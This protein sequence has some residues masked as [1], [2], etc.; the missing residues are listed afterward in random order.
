MPAITTL[1]NLSH[2]GLIEFAGE[3][4]L[5]FLQG[6]LSCDVENLQIWHAQYGSYNTPKG[7]MLASFL[8]WR[9]ADA[10]YMQ[11]PRG[12][13]EPVRKR[14]AIFIL[15]SKV[16]VTDASDGW[17]LFGI[18]GTNAEQLLKKKLGPVPSTPMEMTTAE[19][20]SILKLDSTRFQIIAE[21]DYASQVRDVLADE[22][23]PASREAW[24]LLDIRAGIPFVLPETQ[25][26]FVPQMANLDLVGGVSFSK[27]CYPGQEIVAR[28]HY[29]G[30][31]KQR[32]YLA[33]IETAD[34]PN[35][36]DKVFSSMLGEQAAG[37]LVNAAPVP[38]GGYD[39]LVVMQ[40]ESAGSGD[41]HW[42]SL[43]GPRLQL[44][45]LPYEIPS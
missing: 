12:L 8:L 2:F 33:R 43:D 16:R 34:P 9:T 35:A 45:S 37:M 10:Y 25:E 22:T 40:I 3:E 11:L 41:I 39:A 20:V 15:R 29:L 26:Q 28:M 44:K 21:A 6:Q 17:A 13:C 36:G 38:G 14:I 27:G 31:L 24:D 18:A 7:R 42:K 4:A 1:V 30:K 32:M 19:N 23:I 5:P